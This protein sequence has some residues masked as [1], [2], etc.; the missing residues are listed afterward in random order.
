VSAATPASLRA[1]PAAVRE[2]VTLDG[3]S[4]TPAAVAAVASGAA[5]V[6]VPAGA[7]ARNAAARAALEVLVAAD[8]PVYGVTTGV[9]ALHDRRVAPADAAAHQRALLRSHAA[10]GGPPLP[11]DAV[12]AAMAVRLNQLGAGGAGASDA[13]LDAL[14]AALDADVVPVARSLGALGT[15]DLL[16]LADVGLV[17]LGEGE[18]LVGGQRVPAALALRRAGLT[19]LQPGARDAMAL[20]SSNAVTIARAALLAVRAGGLADAALAVAALSF[21]AVR[22]DRAVLDERVHAARPLP[23]QVAVAARMRALL[24]D[25]PA[26]RGRP[27][28]HDPFA[29]R[30]QPQVDG[31]LADALAALDR[32]LAVELNAAA[33]NPLLVAGPP[34][35]ALPGGNFHAAALALALDGVRAALAQAASLVAARASALLDERFSGVRG[36]LAADAGAS[37]GAMALEYTAHAAAAEVRMLAAPA[38]AQHTSVGA[39]MESHASFAALAIDPTARALDRYADA[40]ATELVLANRA[41]RLTGRAPSRSHAGA[42]AIDPAGVEAALED[43]PLAGDLE[44]ARSALEVR[45]TGAAAPAV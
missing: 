24:G 37:S 29:F 1:A 38:A 27:G 8:E 15:G 10:G 45:T 30:C 6:V 22:A 40:V 31:A 39:G 42:P 4:L 17:L 41:L 36:W 18:A 20:V 33:E 11:P 44:R 5:R 2:A 12:R 16:A 3:R 34:P 23:G 32:V 14:A 26:Q 19:P 9:G 35:A 43:R 28:V 25:A 13:L 21:E 7:R